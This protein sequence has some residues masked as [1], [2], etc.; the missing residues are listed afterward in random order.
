MRSRLKHLM[1]ACALAAAL[2]WT[3]AFA[4]EPIVVIESDMSEDQE[5]LLRSV[6]GEVEAPARS[7]AQARRRA[8]KAA[9]AARSVMRSQ[10]Y[11][12]AQITAEV[13]ETKAE[14]RAENTEDDPKVEDEDVRRPPQAVLKVVRGDPFTYGDLKI[15]FTD[16]P[17]DIEA[18][19]RQELVLDAGAQA[20]AAQ[21]LATE[22]RLVNFLQAKGY[23]E[24]QALPR[25]AV[26]DHAT[27]RMN[28]T[29]N[30]VT[31]RKTRFGKII[32]TGTAKIARSW[33]DMIAPFDEGDIFNIAKMNR[34]AARVTGTGVFDGAVATLA[35]EATENA[36][37]TVTRDV[38][39]KVEQGAINT[40]SAEAGFSTADGTG[41]AVTYE[42]RN[43]IG[44]AQTLT[45]RGTAK[46]NEISAGIAY[47]IPYAWRDDRELDFDAEVARL[48]NE[49]FEGE[50]IK[51]DVLM[52]QKFSRKFR[53][54][55]GLGLEAS[56]FDQEGEEV[57]AYLVEG[58]GRAVFD[59]RDSLLNPSK[60][61]HVEGALVPTYNFGEES[62]AFGTL[63][64]GGLDL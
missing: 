47:N 42:R 25:K 27:K 12:D 56:R 29:Y 58:L 61:F 37:G 3:S 48:D 7:V 10:G 34:L 40:V 18:E 50:R 44:F 36:D 49:A 38:I 35:D 2:G 24:A 21:V 9:E 57:E 1:G 64:L 55:L 17:P 59:N 26:V 53:I 63:T 51:G 43:F 6:L 39:L 13:I 41:V 45:L 22:L 11:Y 4:A 54:G 46:T 60:G 8:E 30:I 5:D 28:V 20:E 31:G 16:G 15:E 19:V 52:T 23:P 62:G 32:Q 14:A 33:P